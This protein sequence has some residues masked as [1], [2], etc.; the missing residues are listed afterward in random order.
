MLSTMY[1]LHAMAGRTTILFTGRGLGLIEQ[2]L[3]IGR[4]L[5]AGDVRL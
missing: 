5:G 4:D 1:L 3:G 2:A